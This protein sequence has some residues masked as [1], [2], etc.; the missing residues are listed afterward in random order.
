MR[1]LTREDVS[2]GKISLDGWTPAL[3]CSLVYELQLHEF[4][5]A[6]AQL[7]SCSVWIQRDLGQSL[8][9]FI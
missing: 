5:K 7:F 9:L 6:K 4:N 1:F 2:Y 3:H 8:S